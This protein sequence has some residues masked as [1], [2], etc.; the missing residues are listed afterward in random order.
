MIAIA[1]SNIH[2]IPP[3]LVRRAI[4]ELN[5][6]IEEMPGEQ[7]NQEILKYWQYIIPAGSTITDEVPWCAAFV[8]WCLEECG[9]ESTR[10]ANARSYETW[11]REHQAPGSICTLWR[12]S[13]DSW[14]GHVGFLLFWDRSHVWLL[15]GNQGDKLSISPFP[16]DRVLSYR[17]PT[18]I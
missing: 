15:G 17:W 5:K 10:K 7:H 1:S 12:G 3:W 9:I 13:A 6:F 11:G 8:G 18:M 2:A 14:Y 16:T 4:P